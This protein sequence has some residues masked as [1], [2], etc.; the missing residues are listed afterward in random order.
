MTVSTIELYCYAEVPAEDAVTQRFRALA[1]H[2]R[3]TVGLSDAD[4]AQQI[5]NDRIDVLVDLAGHTAGNRLLTFA[6]KPAPVQVTY[7]V[8]H[9]YTTGLSAMDA[10]LADAELAP[11]GADPLFS[12]RVIRLSR[13]PL[14]YEPPADMPDVAPLPAQ[15][16]GFVTFGYFGRTVRLNDGVLAAW[17][18]ILHAVPA[19]R[20]MLN[21]APFGEAA[22]RELMI[23]SLRSARYR[24]VPHCACLHLATAADLGGVWRDR[25]CPRPVSAQRR[26]DNDRG[27]VAG[28]SRHHARRPANR[29][30]L[31]CI[32]PACPR[33]GRL[34]NPRCRSATSRAQ[35]RR[36]PTS[37][38]WHNCAP[39]CDRALPPRPCATRSAW[40][41]RWRQPIA[42]CG[43]HG[44]MATG[45]ACGGSWRRATSMAPVASRKP[46]SQ[47]IP[48]T[49]RHFMCSVWLNSARATRQ[50]ASH[51][52][53]ARSQF[54][55]MSTSCRISG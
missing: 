13:I 46:H 28:R 44:A 3:S 33:P 21:S 43:R 1:D 25:H 26:N 10:F 35:S 29:R 20:L 12:E 11:P 38:R 34:D 45:R 30:P 49:W 36:P 16:N 9:G 55:R 18:R 5:R 40:R 53:N 19:S 23:G 17:A 27:V 42:A 24:C 32:D 31:R 41:V 4:L 7:L 39:H 6:R 2:W 51:C 14:A 15:A 54:A 37:C 50:Q 8:G 48:T 52:C 22:G 47:R